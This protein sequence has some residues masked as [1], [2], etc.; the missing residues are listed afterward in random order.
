MHPRQ[1]RRITRGIGA[2]VGRDAADALVHVGHHRDRT[3]GLGR[4]PVG[5]RCD[6]PARARQ[7]A[8][9]VSPVGRMLGH[10]RDG[11]RMQHL[12]QQCP[13][14]TDQHRPIRVDPPGDRVGTEQSRVGG[15]RKLQLGSRS[16]RAAQRR[17]SDVTDERAHRHEQGA[18]RRTDRSRH[19][20]EHCSHDAHLGE[21]RRVPGQSIPRATSESISARNESRSTW[22]RNEDRN[23]LRASSTIWSSA[24]ANAAAVAA[25]FSPRYPPK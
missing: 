1:Q 8:E 25:K 18:R 14:P 2:P 23:E 13:E 5:G 15:G 16:R 10:A 6:E 19:R 9:R 21:S 22:S 7:P 17:A 20:L 11:E 24:N 12:E 4:G 3:F